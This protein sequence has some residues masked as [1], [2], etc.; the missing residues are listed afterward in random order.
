[1]EFATFFGLRVVMTGVLLTL[2]CVMG[3]AE[4][5]SVHPTATL[6]VNGT[7][8]GGGAAWD[9][10]NI[11]ID[12]NGFVETVNY[13]Q[14]S[15]SA[16]LASGFAAMF[17]R[18]YIAFG[19]YAKAG[20]NS[21]SDPSVITFQLVNGSTFGQVNIVGPTTS[22][23]FTQSGFGS[24]P[25]TVADV[26]TATLIVAGTT[27][28]A[29]YGEGS[30]AASI[31]QDL[32]L[33]ANS[34]LVTVTS[35]GSKLFLQSKQT[36]GSFNYPYSLSFSTA[37]SFSGSPLSGNL[38]G[39][40][41]ASPVTVYSYAL[42]Y[43]VGGNLTSMADSVM[44]TWSYSGY[45]IFNRL[46]S[47]SSTNGP[48]A[49]QY[50][51]WSYDAFG[52]RTSQAVSTT[53]CASSPPTTFA[54][55]YSVNNQISSVTSPTNV[56]ISYDAAGNTTYDGYTRYLYDGEGRICATRGA[57]GITAYQYDADGNRI[58]KGAIPGNV[59]PTTCDI[60]QNGYQPATD[61]ILG[62]DS[63]QMS[64]LRIVNGQTMWDH[65][66]VTSNGMLLAT[67][68]TTGLHFHLNDALG[69]RRVQT[70]AAGFPEQTCQSLPF[71]DQLYC[72]GSIT[73]PTEHHFTGKERDTESGLDNFGARYFASS[74]GRW[75]SPDP[76]QLWY[77]D[78][79]NPQSMNLY[80]YASNNPTKYIDNNGEFINLP[81]AG[82]GAAI[83]FATGFLGSAITQEI[84]K[85]SVNFGTAAAYGVGGA[86]TGAL[87]GL[88]FG[89]SLLVSAV[90]DVGIA[91][92]GNAAG[93]VISRS[94]TDLHSDA[95]LREDPFDTNAIT[96][97]LFVGFAGGLI[98]EAIGSGYKVIN[99]TSA[100]K[101]PTPFGSVGNNL[102]RLAN[103]R[104]WQSAQAQVGNRASA[105]S[106]VTG[107]LAGNIFI[108]INSASNN[109][110]G[111]FDSIDLRCARTYSYDSQGNGGWSPCQ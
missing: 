32:A 58:G 96:T 50:A 45:D 80:G 49:G 51:C 77:A 78:P 111:E 108:P 84:S 94:L 100:P 38:T 15:T 13:G 101:A 69:S 91:T 88:T 54:A 52:N 30:T 97:D 46:T 61:Y 83:G 105:F 76:S 99:A 41:E 22:F 42:G 79:A 59:M 47:G 11:T 85:G 20:A 34:S 37:A 6:T 93:G 28:S 26:G 18:D 62:A 33:K 57:F 44:G 3:Y 82:I 5:P 39:S 72:T 43:D 9:G 48:Y 95:T 71:G 16:S 104:D 14:F 73:N 65:T 36:T 21:N 106:A 86:A 64:E 87:A 90:V 102:K 68:D 55:T 12:F 107:A 25:S 92:A 56:T 110:M 66:N 98:G 24:S 17:S 4:T 63:G 89:G 40:T 74:M 75:I 7:E 70:D 103:I 1:M 27:I 60:T 35:E 81:L 10:G 8:Q 53:P 31:A 23:S 2:A 29:N 67:Y 19:L 109:Q